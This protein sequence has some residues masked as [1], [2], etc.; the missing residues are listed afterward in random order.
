M[1]KICSIYPLL[2]LVFAFFKITITNAAGV[3]PIG[4]TGSIGPTGATGETGSTGATGPTGST[5]STGETTTP[6]NFLQ[7][8]RIGNQPVTAGVDVIFNVQTNASVGTTIILNTAT[9]V[10]TLPANKRYMLL[11][12]LHATNFTNAMSNVQFRWVNAATNV[13]LPGTKDNVLFVV[14]YPLTDRTTAVNA[15]VVS[16]GG[17]P[18]TVKVRCFSSANSAQITSYS[19]ALIEELP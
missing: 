7:A 19:S 18:L 12:N 2:F 15:A 6:S 13:Q 1:K 5:G 17:V 16:V 11:A 9:G 14:S 10:F 8:G 4:P 3:G